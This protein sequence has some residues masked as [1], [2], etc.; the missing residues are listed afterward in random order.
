MAVPLSAL[1]GELERCCGTGWR[2][3]SADGAVD[4]LWGSEPDEVLATRV[5]A[6]L[7]RDSFLVIDGG[8]GAFLDG[9]E[10]VYEGWGAWLAAQTPQEAAG[11]DSPTNMGRG[12]HRGFTGW[13]H[14]VLAGCG[15]V[16]T[17]EPGT[18]QQNARTAF[19]MFTE[20]PDACAWPKPAELREGLRDLQV[21]L[22]LLTFV[23][24]RG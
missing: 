9:L 3:V 21:R 5:T 1:V 8:G 11:A 22:E 23:I 18:Y 6:A 12:L 13:S 4:K 14:G 2:E 15:G 17:Q 16:V 10:A 24:R 20:D 7:E 19:H